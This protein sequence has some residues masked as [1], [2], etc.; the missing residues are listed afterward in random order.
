MKYLY[1][2]FCFLTTFSINTFCQVDTSDI[3]LVIRYDHYVQDGVSNNPR[4]EVDALPIPA[5]K[6]DTSYFLDQNK[7]RIKILIEVKTGDTVLQYIEIKNPGELP[8]IDLRKPIGGIPVNQLQPRCPENSQ[9]PPQMRQQQPK[10]YVKE[11]AFMIKGQYLND[12]TIVGTAYLVKEICLSEVKEYAEK[13]TF[14]KQ[15]IQ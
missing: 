5:F 1:M 12:S 3:K 13:K 2:I 6:I 15:L 4:A 14:L 10:S 9:M 8:I 7:N 11:R